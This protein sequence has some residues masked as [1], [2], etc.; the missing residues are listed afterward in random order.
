TVNEGMRG[1]F[2]V[3]IT[4]VRENRA[5]LESRRIDVPWNNKDLNLAWE[6]FTSKLQPG[7]KETWTLQ[8]T[9][10]LTNKNGPLSPRALTEVVAT[11]YDESLDAFLEHHWPPKF[12]F[13]RYDHSAMN[14][15]FENATRHFQWIHGQWNYGYVSADRT[16]RHFPSDLVQNFWGYQFARTRGAM[17]KMNGEAQENRLMAGAMLAAEA[18]AASAGLARSDFLADKDSARNEPGTPPPPRGPDLGQVTARKNLNETAF[19]FPQL[20]CD[21]NSVIKLQFTMPEALTK[22]RFFGFAHDQQLRSGFLEGHTVTSKDLMVQ[23]N[24]PRFLRE[25]DMLEFTV[26]VSNQSA[27]RQTGK[28]RLTFN[29]ALNDETAD[30]LLGNADTERDFDVPSKESRSYSWRIKVPDGLGFLSY[31][32]V[33]STGKISDGEEGYLPVL[34]RRIFVTESLALPIRGPGT[35]T[36]E[37]TKLLKS[38]KSDT[39]QHRNVTVQM[40]SQPAWY[41]VMALPYLMEFPHECSEQIF[42]RLYANSVGRYIAGSDPKI[43]RIFDQ[44]KNTTALDS[45]LEKNQDLKSVLVEETPWLRQ[46]QDESQARRNV[47]VLFDDN[48]MEYEI[49][50]A[51][52]QLAEMQLPDGAWPWFPGGRGNDYITLYIVTGFGRMRHLGVDANMQPAIRALSRLD[53]WM[54]E[55]YRDIQKWP[56]P[57][58]YVPSPTD[59]LYLYTRSF[60]LKDQAIAAAHKPAIEFFLKQSR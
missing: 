35:K 13:F 8:I 39:L 2:T 41:A 42:N 52:Q 53:N 24:P 22:W 26:K 44:W 58:K 10:A 23:P 9:P 47:G 19:F 17:Y 38:G 60:F 28:V 31:K 40:V 20:I 6:H 32:A 21:S 37:F 7:Q 48:R 1:G 4:Y 45:P 15:Q 49:G 34:S 5:Y 46:A 29:Q 54:D 59:A 16:Y 25:G 55:H 27:A 3:H 14:R 18:P 57:E 56:D 51:F 12:S 36:F 43:R 11:L 33:A 50:R 30:K